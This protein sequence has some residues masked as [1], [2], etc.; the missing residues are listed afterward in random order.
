MPTVAGIPPTEARRKEIEGSHGAWMA[1][2]GDD[3]ERLRLRASDETFRFEFWTGDSK[4]KIGE[5]KSKKPGKQRVV[6][7][8]PKYRKNGGQFAPKPDYEK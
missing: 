1:L 5:P 3:P 8:H 4:K 2:G 7:R 6:W